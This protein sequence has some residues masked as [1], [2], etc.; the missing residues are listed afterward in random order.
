MEKKLKKG[1]GTAMICI[2]LFL[3]VCTADGSKHE[4]GLRLTG[5]ALF[6]VGAWLAE[7]YDWQT[8]KKATGLAPHQAEGRGFSSDEETILYRTAFSPILAE[9]ERRIACLATPTQIGRASCR[10]RV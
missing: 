7:A 8:A 4:I 2:G 1:I 9:C 5:V 10:E 3:A 6:A